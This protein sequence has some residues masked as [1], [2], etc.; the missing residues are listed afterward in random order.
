VCCCGKPSASS[1]K[2]DSC[3]W[4]ACNSTQRS[5]TQRNA[6]HLLRRAQCRGRRLCCCHCSTSVHLPPAAA[7][8][9]LPQQWGRLARQR[10]HELVAAARAAAA[11]RGG[12]I[13]S[14]C[15]CPCQLQ[16]TLPAVPGVEQC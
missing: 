4:L 2:V 7:R 6:T 10:W 8:L 16:H 5:A 15:C 3:V 12:A 14:S 1:K 11:A 9:L 13:T